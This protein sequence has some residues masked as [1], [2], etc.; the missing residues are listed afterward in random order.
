MLPQ[1]ALPQLAA[2]GR[3]ERQ[4]AVATQDA[5]APR[6]RIAGHGRAS[7]ARRARL[8]QRGAKQARVRAATVPLRVKRLPPV[9]RGIDE[10]HQ[11]GQPWIM[12]LGRIRGDVKLRFQKLA[13]RILPSSRIGRGS[14]PQHDGQYLVRERAVAG[15]ARTRAQEKNRAGHGSA[16]L[17][18][19]GL[20]QAA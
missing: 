4:A 12:L 20:R 18:E 8:V 19:F 9:E 11:Q 17:G 1:A 5:A 10:T 15:L 16:R 3:E 14:A 2:W 6:M 7:R 13:D